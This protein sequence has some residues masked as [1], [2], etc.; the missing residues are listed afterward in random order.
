M[1][2]NRFWSNSAARTSRRH[3][4]DMA[5]RPSRFSVR[6]D[7]DFYPRCILKI[8]YGFAVAMLGLEGIS[9]AAVLPAILGQRD[10]SGMWLGCDGVRKL[11]GS[12]LH[13]YSIE[14]ADRIIVRIG[15]FSPVK[16]IPEYVAVIGKPK[17]S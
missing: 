6:H 10:D 2:L 14:V 9:E 5:Q 3:S 12:S 4:S 11:P 16:S 13:E 7:F 8:A 1:S 15:L 17:V